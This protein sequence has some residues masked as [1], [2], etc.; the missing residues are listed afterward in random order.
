MAGVLWEGLAWWAAMNVSPVVEL[1]AQIYSLQLK[2]ARNI[3]KQ[4][5]IFVFCPV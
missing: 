2:T 4:L 3:V 1:E 5:E